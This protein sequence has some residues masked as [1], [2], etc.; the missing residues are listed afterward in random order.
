MCFGCLTGEVAG[1]AS[2]DAQH[3]RGY[4]DGHVAA[5]DEGRLPATGSMLADVALDGSGDAA[6]VRGH[7]E[8]HVAAQDEGDSSAKASIIAGKASGDAQD[9]TL[10]YPAMTNQDGANANAKEVFFFI[11]SKQTRLADNPLPSS[12]PP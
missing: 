11:F 7:D 12:P 1:D 3:V 4:N 8:G 9:Q 5:Q 6:H 2:G 10:G